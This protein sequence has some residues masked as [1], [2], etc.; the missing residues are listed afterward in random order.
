MIIKA[1]SLDGAGVHLSGQMLLAAVV[2]AQWLLA[3]L[4]SVAAPVRMKKAMLVSTAVFA[5]GWLWAFDA[6]SLLGSKS[7]AAQAA[8]MAGGAKHAGSCASVQN[9]MW[10]DDVRKKLGSP[11]EVRSDDVVR[12]PGSSTLVYRDLRC[13]VHLFDDKVELVD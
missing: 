5:A 8:A 7:T 12:G 1:L 13:A 11:D 2:A 9:G 10:A 3:G 6:R 4:L